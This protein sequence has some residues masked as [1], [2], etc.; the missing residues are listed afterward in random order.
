MPVVGHQQL[1]PTAMFG[2]RQG[3]RNN[4]NKRTGS[5]GPLETDTLACWT[6]ILTCDTTMGRRL[7][8]SLRVGIYKNV[9]VSAKFSFGGVTYLEQQI[10]RLKSEVPSAEKYQLTIDH[11]QACEN[12]T[13]VGRSSHTQRRHTLHKR[14]TPAQ[15]TMHC[16][17][18]SH[19][20]KQSLQSTHAHTPRT[21]RLKQ[22][23]VT[24]DVTYSN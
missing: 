15:H 16:H 12:T 13:A 2:R 1:L 11:G 8:Q 4:R 17:S 19:S 24:L 6:L 21:V 3:G 5:L 14:R 18:Q 20:A 7:I 10:S 23:L 22:E 9:R